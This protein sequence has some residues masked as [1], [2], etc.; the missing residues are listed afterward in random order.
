MKV[1]VSLSYTVEERALQNTKSNNCTYK[2]CN[3]RA[4]E[5]NKS[6]ESISGPS[7]LTILYIMGISNLHGTR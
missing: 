6:L 3:L 7:I 1:S 5:L 4:E 2:L